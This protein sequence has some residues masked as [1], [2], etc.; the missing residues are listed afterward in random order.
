MRALHASAS[1]KRPRRQNQASAQ[2]T[3]FALSALSYRHSV[4]RARER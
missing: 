4:A 2:V 3:A 1:T